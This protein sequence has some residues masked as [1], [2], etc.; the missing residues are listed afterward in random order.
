ME[1]I[2]SGFEYPF[3]SSPQGGYTTVE[4][5]NSAVRWE[6]SKQLDV[7]TDLSM[8]SGKLLF[9]IDYF[10]KVTEDQ[11]V[12]NT[13]PSSAGYASPAWI[14]VGKTLNSGIEVELAHIDE[15][16]DDFSYSISANAAFLHNEVLELALTLGF[17]F[18]LI[19]QMRR[20]SKRQRTA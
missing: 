7:G 11:L 8:Y 4:L 6:T 2:N 20:F 14:N 3:G 5:G 13:N 18:F 1:K 9:T 17:F 10:R 12:R 19:F 16:S 15:I